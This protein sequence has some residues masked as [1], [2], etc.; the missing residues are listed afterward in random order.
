MPRQKQ[1]QIKVTVTREQDAVLE[2]LS[3]RLQLGKATLIRLLVNEGLDP[4]R[5]LL[6]AIDA[7]QEDA[8][9]AYVRGLIVRATDLS[10]QLRIPYQFRAPDEQ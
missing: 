10:T 1:I 4:L 9:G 8:L 5:E 2:Q 6:R 7:G 3:E